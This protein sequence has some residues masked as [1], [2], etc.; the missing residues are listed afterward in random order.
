MHFA[1]YQRNRSPLHV[2]HIRH[3][4]SGQW[5][6]GWGRLGHTRIEMRSVVSGVHLR[7]VQER[8]DASWIV[9][10]HETEAEARGRG[11]R[12]VIALPLAH[13]C[14]SKPRATG[15]DRGMSSDQVLTDKL[16]ASFPTTATGL[17]LLADHGLELRSSPPR[18]AG[19]RGTAPE[20]DRDALW[21]SPRPDPY[22]FGGAGG[23][24][25]GGSPLARGVR[26]ER[27]SG[28]ER[29]GELALRILLQELRRRNGSG[30]PHTDGHPGAGAPSRAAR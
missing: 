1:G 7:T 27:S 15:L 6:F 26:L 22:A 14:R 11:D 16:F 13:A 8:A 19:L 21:R 20:R 28:E 3:V 10:T 24:R 5:A 12:P 29:F 2:P 4:A 30:G 23:A 17:Q 9:S 18:P 25:P